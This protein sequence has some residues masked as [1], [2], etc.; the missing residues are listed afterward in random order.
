MHDLAML[1][2]HFSFLVFEPKELADKAVAA[3]EK[4]IHADENV[5]QDHQVEKKV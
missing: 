4:E 5:A 1:T 2:Q 3:V